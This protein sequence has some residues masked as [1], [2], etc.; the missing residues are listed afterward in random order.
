MARMG[1]DMV[2]AGRNGDIARLKTLSENKILLRNRGEDAL[3][4]ACE[5][6]QL[7]A[8]KFLHGKGVRVN[9]FY[10]DP[11][12]A[13]TTI[14][15]YPFHIALQ[16]K[17]WRVA[18][19]LMD[20]KVDPHPLRWA[21]WHLAVAEEWHLFARAIVA[22]DYIGA[23]LQGDSM[24]STL[25]AA[26]GCIMT[27]DNLQG[28]IVCAEAGVPPAMLLDR[29]L[30][31]GA[32]KILKEMLLRGADVP[33]DLVLQV[34]NEEPERAERLA[35]QRIV[36]AWGYDHPLDE[37]VRVRYRAAIEKDPQAPGAHGESAAFALTRGG[38]FNT[39]VAPLL[40]RHGAALLTA[41]GRED[42]TV[43]DVARRRGELK[44][45]FS[46]A[47]WNGQTR[48][49]MACINALPARLQTDFD[50]PAMLVGFRQYSLGA[51]RT[52]APRL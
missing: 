35:V 29:A 15:N 33:A 52:R 28:A 44:A 46:P 38:H 48:A 31:S 19:W 17:H 8:A 22:E 1:N 2:L 50:I 4:E 39:D 51:R 25:A 5:H 10:L 27:R 30:N 42:A 36:I 6:G 37:T 23:W 43:G 20:Q 45:A 41:T 9:G 32:P 16:N 11:Y 13:A 3:F 40:P 14:S 24:N 26:I 7:A 47:A 34:L 18:E 12:N 49:M 21:L